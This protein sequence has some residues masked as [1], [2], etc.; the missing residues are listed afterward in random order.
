MSKVKLV[1]REILQLSIKGIYRQNIN[2][3]ATTS[4]AFTKAANR[5]Q[6]GKDIFLAN[7]INSY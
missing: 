1:F 3:K 5:Q 4:L 6:A 2:P 7:K